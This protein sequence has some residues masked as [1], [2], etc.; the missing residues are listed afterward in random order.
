MNE[1][2]MLS[3]VVVSNDEKKLNGML[4]SSLEMQSFTDYELIVVD[5]SKYRSASSAYNT[6]AKQAIGKYILFL[7]H[8]IIFT[9]VHAVEKMM[10]Y[11]SLL[12]SNQY[13]LLGFAGVLGFGKETKRI[14]SMQN[15]ADRKVFSYKE[16]Q[17]PE[18]CFSVDE[19]GFM[20][21]RKK[22]LQYGFEDLGNTWHLYAVELCLHI[23]ANGERVGVMPVDV[24]HCSL[25]KLN[26]DYY[27]KIRVLAKKYEKVFPRI[28]TTC[29]TVDMTNPRWKLLLIKRQVHL[30]LDEHIRN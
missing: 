9:S 23:K 25:G 30:W 20:M 4:R 1:K 18:E 28:F 27:S 14:M 6:G 24:W 26:S 16:L 12:D 3:F 19:C 13:A 17:E 8:D 29:I 10:N 21:E 11:V 15:G 7:H 5:G 22:F 2:K